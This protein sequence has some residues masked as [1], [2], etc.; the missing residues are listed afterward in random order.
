[1]EVGL[2]S[3][4][5][6]HTKVLLAL[7]SLLL[8]LLLY[9]TSLLSEASALSDIFVDA[10]VYTL[11]FL[12]VIVLGSMA[13][14]GYCLVEEV[15]A[16]GGSSY[17]PQRDLPAVDKLSGQQL[18]SAVKEEERRPDGEA[19]HHEIEKR[20]LPGHMG[21]MRGL[22]ALTVLEPEKVSAYLAQQH[23]QVAAAILAM[24]EQSKADAVLERFEKV[25]REDV[26]ERLGDL[27]T[28]HPDVTVRLNDALQR[29]FL[30]SPE[31]YRCL[32]GLDNAA[33]RT[34]LRSVDKKELMFA[35]SEMTQELQEK[36]F[37]NMWAEASAECRQ[38][39][40]SAALK[41]RGRGSE[42]VK[43]LCLLAER[44]RENGRIHT[45]KKA[46]G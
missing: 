38:V 2:L 16:C 13:F 25:L 29:E 8:L 22:E 23:P 10:A 3:R 5:L 37:A 27:D 24:L 9:A 45:L 31:R 17:I 6:R 39:L 32:N 34:L 41:E 4:L 14:V 11:Y 44:P 21:Q 46:M 15:S 19:A 42:A 12:L 35:L 43:K 1:M 7:L 33:V 18:Q 40:R 20:S 26:T 30:I 36:F 28:V